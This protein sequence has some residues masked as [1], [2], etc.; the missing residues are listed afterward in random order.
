MTD[1]RSALANHGILPRNGRHISPSQ[2]ASALCY[3]YNLSPT[4]AN[5]L[6]LP[7]EPLWTGVSCSSLEG[8][9]AKR[10]LTFVWLAARVVQPGR[11]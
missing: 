10:G 5:Q 11:S 7:F 2:L 9:S 1:L 3:A 6:A 8:L 4:L